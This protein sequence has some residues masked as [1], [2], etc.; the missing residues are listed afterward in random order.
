MFQ[1]VSKSLGPRA[2]EQLGLFESELSVT[3]V[4]ATAITG[5]F[6]SPKPLLVSFCWIRYT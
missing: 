4:S 3:V 1:K 2:G 5:T 6:R